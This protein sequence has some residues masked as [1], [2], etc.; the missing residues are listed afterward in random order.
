MKK[1]LIRLAVAGVLSLGALTAAVPAQAAP[2]EYAPCA[3]LSAGETKFSGHGANRVIFT[4]ARDYGVNQVL[5]TSCVNTGGGYAQEWQTTGF[6]G[7]NGFAPPGK[8]WENTWYSPTGSFTTTEALGR[9]NPGT[10]L[11]YHTVNPN[12]RWGGE[13]GATYNQY[14]E[15]VGGESDE[16]L[17][18]YMNQ[19][20]YE[21]A[22]VINW[23]RQPDMAVTQ[24]ASYAIFFHAG[25]ATSAGCISTDLGTV[26]RVIQNAVPGDRFIMGTVNDV[27]SPA[28]PPPAPVAPAPAPVA[29]APAPAPVPAVVEPEPVVE[30]VVEEPAPEA[31]PTPE[32]SATPEPT[33]TETPTETATSTAIAIPE[34]SPLPAS[35]ASS[36]EEDNSSAF[37]TMGGSLLAVL[38]IAAA[39][40]AAWKLR[41]FKPRKTTP[42]H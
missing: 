8:M 17:Y 2:Q 13:Y 30:P 20:Y 42:K 33:V 11:A 16:N 35:E 18:T 25:N 12:S 40:F 5:I 27:F 22:A 41:I 34:I 23:N 29:P 7:L 10:A 14:F 1:N 21:Q 3:K 4:T 24:G 31:T 39:V 6:G 15:G 36:T 28:A 26:T 9:Y 32:P 19:G 37:L 38:G